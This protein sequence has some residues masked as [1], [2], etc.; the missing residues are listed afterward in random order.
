MQSISTSEAQI[1]NVN[2]TTNPT[3]IADIYVGDLP[4]EAQNASAIYCRVVISADD[5][6]ELYVWDWPNAQQ[7]YDITTYYLTMP[8]VMPINN[9]QIRIRLMSAPEN[10]SLS[11]FLIGWW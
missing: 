1:L 4:E 7:L 10:Y 3:G 6:Y 5:Y 2:Q 11:V 8:I 9:G